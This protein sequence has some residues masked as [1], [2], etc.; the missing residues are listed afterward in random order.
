MITPPSEGVGILLRTL[1]PISDRGISISEI[2]S[3]PLREQFGEYCF[4]LTIDRHEDE[5]VVREAVAELTGTGFTV[6][7]LGSYPAWR[8]PA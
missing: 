7:L 3:R 1:Q 5:P 6:K 4:L 2:V 8:E